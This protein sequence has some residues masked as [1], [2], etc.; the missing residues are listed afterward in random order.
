MKNI[1][2]KIIIGNWKMNLNYKDSIILSKKIVHSLKGKRIKNEVVVLPDFSALSS[3]SQVIKK[4]LVLGSQDVAGNNLGAYTGE[5]SLESLKQLNC[6]YILIGHSERRQYFFD[7]EMVANKMK[8]VL[9]NSGITPILCIGETLGQKR[10]GKTLL[11]LEKQIKTAFSKIKKLSNKKIIIAYEPVWAIGTGRIITVADAIA[12][13][14]KIK[15]LV[16]KICHNNLPKELGIVYG[17][18]V[19][20]NNFSN[21]KNCPDIS[22][23]LI[24]GTSLKASDFLNIVN[25]F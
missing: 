24:G 20:I 15:S 6:S 18:S 3:I 5:V 17:G 7:D 9:E 12:I 25:N 13:H 22:G 16:E 2:K 1:S 19:N 4:P 21:F 23:L 10:S 8:N 11:I 14:K